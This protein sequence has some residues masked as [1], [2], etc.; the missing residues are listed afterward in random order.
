M[1]LSLF[2]NED[3]CGASSIFSDPSSITSLNTLIA[4][5]AYDQNLQKG[6]RIDVKASF[7]CLILNNMFWLHIMYLLRWQLWITSLS[8]CHGRPRSRRRTYISTTLNKIYLAN[9]RSWKEWL[10]ARLLWARFGNLAILYSMILSVY[11]F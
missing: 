10:H 1:S 3:I 11:L 9:F 8:N 6:T 4:L 2:N 5:F 7:T